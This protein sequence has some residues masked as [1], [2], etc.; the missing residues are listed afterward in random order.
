MDVS[1]PTPCDVEGCRSLATGAY[2]STSRAPTMRLAI[3]D[4]HFAELLGGGRLVVLE[5]TQGRSPQLRVE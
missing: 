2:L 1:E 3:C 5:P 4:L